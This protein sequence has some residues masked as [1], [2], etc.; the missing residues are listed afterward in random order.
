MTEDEQYSN[1]HLEPEAIKFLSLPG[2]NSDDTIDGTNPEDCRLSTELKDLLSAAKT[3][4]DDMQGIT[5][6]YECRLSKIVRRGKTV[7]INVKVKP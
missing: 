4:S 1:T 2:V 7:V 5:Y 6:I 3:Y